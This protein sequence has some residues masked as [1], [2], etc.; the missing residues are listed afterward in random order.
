MVGVELT[1]LQKLWH[2]FAVVQEATVKEKDKQRDEIAEVNEGQTPLNSLSKPERND[3]NEQSSI[4]PA[5][6]DHCMQCDEETQVWL[7]RVWRYNLQDT[8]HRRSVLRAKI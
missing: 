1:M 4:Q 5:H 3:S 6:G 2:H 8:S 7:L